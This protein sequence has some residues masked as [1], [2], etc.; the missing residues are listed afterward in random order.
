MGINGPCCRE[1]EKEGGG[2]RAGYYRF[3]VPTYTGSGAWLSRAKEVPT[4]LTTVIWFNCSEA[5]LLSGKYTEE[6]QENS[7]VLVATVA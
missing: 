2:G 5:A 6:V 4:L 1:L 7:E 3:Q